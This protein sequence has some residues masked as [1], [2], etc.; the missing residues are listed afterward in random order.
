MRAPTPAV[1]AP[2]S[3][4]RS[5]L[6]W[7]LV[8][9]FA[10]KAGVLAQLHALPLLQPVGTTDGAFYLAL[11]RRVASGDL[12]LGPGPFHVAPLYAYVL[13][14][15]LAL[16]GGGL[17]LPAVV[18]IGLGTAAVGLVHATARRLAGARAALVA[19]L[20]ATLCGV[21]TFDELRIQHGALDPFLTALALW[22]W[23]RA[24][25][26]DAPDTA[27]ATR[28]WW[29]AGLALGLLALNRP[30]AL[31]L[32]LGLPVLLMALRGPR[33]V[34]RQAALVLLGVALA[35][36]PATIH[37]LVQA[38]EP[39]WIAAHGGLN[40]YIGNNPEADGTYH[41]VPGIEPSIAGQVVDARRLA[42]AALGRRLSS[43]E[44]SNWFGARA[45]AWW[46][47]EPCDALLLLV[48]KLAYVG[49]QVELPLDAAY[50]FYSRDL[51]GLLG[52][53]S[54][55]AG[56]LVP[57]GLA[58]CVWQAWRWR[59]QPDRLRTDLAWMACLPLYALSVAV[60]FV[61]SRYRLPLL[62]PLCVGTGLAGER[63]LALATRSDARRELLVGVLLTA[64][65]AWGANH[66]FG[67][68]DGRSE[69]RIRY[70]EMLVDSG[71]LDAAHAMVLRFERDQ[72][73][74]A[75]LWARA[76]QALHERGQAA[77]ATTWLARASTLA[78]QD[79]GLHL[80]LVRA[81]LSSG[82][83]A[84][85]R[86]HLRALTAATVRSTRDAPSALALGALALEW[87]QA[88][89]AQMLL[90]AALDAGCSPA[91]PAHEK[92]GLALALE[93]RLDEA[94]V[95]LER[96]C[97]LDSGRA[98]AQL[99]RAVVLAQLGRIGPAR[100]AARAALR[101]Q[102]AYPQARG[103]L[104]ALDDSGAR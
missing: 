34:W 4:L 100:D 93:D 104:A 78:P 32:A 1:A 94:L 89:Q 64:A 61:T 90:R 31:A 88:G 62:L 96:A 75:E 59:G 5:F 70:V 38:G 29:L 10:L 74:P 103:L 54:L 12:A 30:N 47:A 42:E 39:V 56:G 25:R 84:E 8:V 65:L 97:H 81:W 55:G 58:G 23:V 91:A 73:R 40:L 44:V 19:A 46:R 60:F 28:S 21:L 14:L 71:Q 41:H 48:R 52:F 69:E 95:E 86:A 68:D 2:R 35:V 63:V 13:G 92:L 85:A 76:G 9:T 15:L 67:L 79:L 27:A 18:Q 43:L 82:H 7:W 22:A 50:S 49:N 3:R 26:P 87:Q 66:D 99:N 36:A 17:L 37:N 98:S 33:L 102:P 53:L 77:E 83:E 20:A 101:L 51:P 72:A 16:G 6:P 24:L 80:A 57:L 11:A 45:V